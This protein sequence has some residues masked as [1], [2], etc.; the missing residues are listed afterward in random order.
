METPRHDHGPEAVRRLN[1]V[2]GHDLVACVHEGV[3]R[4]IKRDAAGVAR[5]KAL[6][7]AIVREVVAVLRRRSRPIRGLSPRAFLDELDSSRNA[8]LSR[9]QEALRELR[10][11]RRRVRTVREP[12]E[13]EESSA[14]ELEERIRRGVAE[15]VEH[16]QADHFEPND[17]VER[18][19]EVALRVTDRERRRLIDEGSARRAEL[20]ERRIRKLARSLQRTEAEIERFHELGNLDLGIASVYK[21]VQGLDD[22]DPFWKVKQEL[23]QSIFAANLELRRVEKRERVSADAS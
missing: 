10:E 14:E 3:T 4:A 23:L 2:P 1:L 20:L 19:V 12:L 5:P 16:M 11:V 6:R 22:D 13:R 18:V 9:R 21:S 7:D 8:I 17:L 15:T